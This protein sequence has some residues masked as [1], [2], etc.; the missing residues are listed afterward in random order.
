MESKLTDKSIL[1]VSPEPWSHIFV[2]KH[3]YAIHL[4]AKGNNVFFL[5]PP[6]DKYDIESSEYDGLKIISYKGFVTGLRMMPKFIR[7]FF[8]KKVFNKIVKIC[9][10][11]FQ[12]VWSFDNSVFY[13][14]D[15]LPED[16][17]KISHI[18]DLNQHFQLEKAASSA[19]ICFCTT[20]HILEKLLKSN[21]KSFFIN[22]GYNYQNVNNNEIELPGN[23]KLKA[24]YVG[25]LSMK[26]I[27]W[28]ILN[29][30]IEKFPHID[31]IF[32]GPNMNDFDLSLNKYHEYKKEVCQKQNVFSVGK[33]SSND[34]MSFLKASQILMISYQEAHHMD[35]ANPHKILEYLGSGVPIIATFTEQYQEYS[36]L[37]KM[38][39]Y[40]K[41]W[42]M[43]FEELLNSKELYD[44]DL[45]KER[46]KLAL[47]NTYEKQIERIENLI[48][49]HVQS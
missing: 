44:G 40:N 49:Q 19:D 26:Y 20:S 28:N 18:V 31:F 45:K 9:D 17:C 34:I 27:D 11:K 23:N 22:H 13:D 5:N 16:I 37:I 41:D 46:I 10:S 29:K 42:V 35:Q 39:N 15:F 30:A 33:I 8:V 36:N 12:I 38:P 32:I 1:I 3:H 14:L 2:S 43:N 7:G 6:S 25:N 4:A 24:L 21:R 47:E 48:D